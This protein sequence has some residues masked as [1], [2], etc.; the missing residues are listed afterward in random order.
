MKNL[1]GVESDDNTRDDQTIQK[2][3]TKINVRL[4]LLAE[5]PAL[6]LA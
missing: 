3:V 2:L 5:S 6:K 1:E 4:N